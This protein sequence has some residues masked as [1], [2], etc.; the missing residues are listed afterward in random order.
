[1]KPTFLP[2]LLLVLLPLCAA[3]PPSAPL[4]PHPIDCPAGKYYHAE[5]H[6]CINCPSGRY[7]GSLVESEQVIVY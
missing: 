5:S 1:M 6:S 2:F 7:G 4:P 3:G